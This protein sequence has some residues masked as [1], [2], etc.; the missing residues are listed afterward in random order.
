MLTAKIRFL[1]PVFL[2]SFLLALVICV[3]LLLTL[4]EAIGSDF[5]SYLTGAEIIKASKGPL[6][7]DLDTQYFYQQSVLFPHH[8]TSILPFVN[9]PIIAFI[10]IPF[11]YLP[12]IWAYKIYIGLL[13]SILL[14]ISNFSKKLFTNLPK[15]SIF[16]YLPFLFY[17]SLGSLFSGQL[18]PIILLIFLVIY[19]QLIKKKYMYAGLMTGLL[20]VKIQYLV[21]APILFV[22]AENKKDFLKGFLISCILLFSVNLLLARNFFL[23]HYLQFI[24]AVQKPEFGARPQEMFTFY[25]SL[26]QLSAF[27]QFPK[28]VLIS[29]NFGFYL[30]S[31]VL[32][33]LS[34]KRISLD[35]S[36][37]AVVICSMIFSIHGLNYDYSLV[38]VPV[39]ILLNRLYNRSTAFDYEKIITLLL[40]VLPILFVVNRALYVSFF[41]LGILI[42]LIY[43]KFTNFTRNMAKEA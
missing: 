36:Y 9:F 18:T 17:P 42:F 29:L 11:T 35:I 40:L 22:L 24:F 5:V 1:K 34:A 13:I 31:L 21:S 10:L 16:Y 15:N 38:I 28:S 14:V 23:P 2:I 25:S 43:G 39:F 37:A 19:S 12:L 7:Y 3:F 4:R 6:L 27:A 41:L 8:E 30:L 32:I 26:E 33:A 20:I